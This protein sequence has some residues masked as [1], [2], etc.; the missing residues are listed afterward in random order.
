VLAL[1]LATLAAAPTPRAASHSDTV[2]FVPRLDKLDGVGAFTARAGERSVILRPASWSPEFHPLLYLE[3]TRPESL[4]QNGVDPAGDATVSFIGEGRMSCLSLADP[5]LF[6][7]RAQEAL[8]GLGTV[9]RKKTGST[10][11]VT[12]TLESTLR[13][14]YAL[15]G[16]YACAFR[17]PL[18]AGAKALALEASARVARPGPAGDLATALSLHGAVFGTSSGAAWAVNATDQT[19]TLEVKSPRSPLPSL[20]APSTN[21]YGGMSST[22][23]F[24]ARAQ[25]GR[26][27]LPRLADVLVAQ[28]LAVCPPCNRAELSALS[29]QLAPLMTGNLAV[30]LDRLEVK[31]SLRTST[32][33]YFALRHAYLAE[34]SDPAAARALLARLAAQKG[35]QAEGDGYVLTVPGGRI[36]VGVAGPHLYVANDPVALKAALGAVPDK[37]GKG[38]HG[39]EGWLDPRLAAHALGQISLF[40]VMSS[41]ELASLFAASTELGPLLGITSQV[42]AHADGAAPPVWSA[43]WTLTPTH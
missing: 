31:D 24:F 28:V 1:C 26:G 15:S 33:R 11:L 14:G 25:I 5:A 23:L 42:V 6:E 43:S 41:Q 36:E 27:E 3:P 2:V 16:R 18:D 19:L 4:S 8:S 20:R 40:D 10:W 22:G 37:P 9:S 12:A 39:A 29:E 21:I 7:K 17:H 38:A 30:R 34:L 35:A 13:G 32:G